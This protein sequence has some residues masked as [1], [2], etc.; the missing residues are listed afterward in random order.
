MNISRLQQLITILEEVEAKSQP[1]DMVAWLSTCGTAACAWGWGALHPMFQAQGVT[2]KVSLIKEQLGEE[3][4]LQELEIT[5]LSEL[6]PAL[7][8]DWQ[9]FFA[10]PTFE[11]AEGM[12]AATRFFDL[13]PSQA[14]HLFSHVGYRQ[15]GAWMNGVRPRHV[16]AKIQALLA[17][18]VS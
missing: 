12:D 16:I 18:P 9:V 13:T 6:Q 7:N 17:E 10:S 3:D 11:G 2:M 4:E 1:F 8:E 14:T 15:S 5:S